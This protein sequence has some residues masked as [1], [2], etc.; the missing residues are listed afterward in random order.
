[1]ALPHFNYGFN[2]GPARRPMPGRQ[3][4]QFGAVSICAYMNLNE[5][6]SHNSMRTNEEAGSSITRIG[7]LCD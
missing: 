4:A 3:H 5:N 1:M 6:Q 7:M 2:N